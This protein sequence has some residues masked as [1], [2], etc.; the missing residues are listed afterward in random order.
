[1]GRPVKRSH[2]L[3]SIRERAAQVRTE[4]WGRADIE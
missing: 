3:Y 1:M 4:T 2:D